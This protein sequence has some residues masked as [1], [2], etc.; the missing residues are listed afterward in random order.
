[1]HLLTKNVIYCPDKQNNQEKGV[2]MIFKLSYPSSTQFTP[3]YQCHET[4]KRIEK[5]GDLVFLS[6]PNEHLVN[7][8]FTA[9]CVCSVN[10]TLLR[11]IPKNRRSKTETLW[12]QKDWRDRVNV[13][14]SN[15]HFEHRNDL[16]GD[17]RYLMN[18][19]RDDLGKFLFSMTKATARRYLP[20]ATRFLVS[21]Q[22]KT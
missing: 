5:E 12:R 2:A 3:S 19:A 16:K 10:R 17:G 20:Q 13:F 15:A 6:L 22:R 9:E 18:H 14:T 7:S 21:K 8:S 1:L 11:L 4:D